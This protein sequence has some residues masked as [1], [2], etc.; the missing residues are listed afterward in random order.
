ME[1]NISLL[2]INATHSIVERVMP[3]VI[4]RLSYLLISL[5]E[6]KIFFFVLLRS[7]KKYMYCVQFYPILGASV[8]VLIL[9]ISCVA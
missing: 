7:K 5:S 2:N 8:V 3:V 6:K 9:K 1:K 4:N